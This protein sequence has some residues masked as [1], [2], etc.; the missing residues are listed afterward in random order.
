V[1]GVE[2]RK[3]VVAGYQASG[4]RFFDENGHRHPVT[5]MQLRLDIRQDEGPPGRNVTLAVIEFGMGA[6][7][8]QIGS[9]VPRSAPHADQFELDVALPASEFDH[10][11][12]ILTDIGQTHL[13]CKL[14]RSPEANVTEFKIMSRKHTESAPS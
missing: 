12:N 13:R 7:Q 14:E 10:Y 6:E 2:V 5:I 1:T 11:W 8:D 3:Y 4:G 9:I